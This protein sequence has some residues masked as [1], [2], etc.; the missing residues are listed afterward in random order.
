MAQTEINGGG[1][2]KNL[3][4][5]YRHKE[6]GAEIVI[7]DNPGIGSSKADGAVQVGFEYVGPAPEET[8]TVTKEAPVADPK[9]DKK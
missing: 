2:P 5:L 9:T 4:G 7:T 6:S 3:P 8:K 1:K